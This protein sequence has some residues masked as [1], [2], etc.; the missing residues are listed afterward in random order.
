MKVIAF[1]LPQFHDI[2]EN[3]KWW[4]KGFT[5]WTNVKKARPLFDGHRQPRTP[6]NDN[7][8]CLLDDDV[9]VWQAKI[10]KEHGIYG[11]CYYH[12]WFLG[13]KLLEKPMEQMLA[14]PKIDIPFCICW[15]NDAWTKAWVGETKTIMEQK[16][17][18]EDD[19][20][21]HFNY[22]LSFFKDHRYIKEDNKP[23]V[24]IYRPEIIECLN[25]M[26][27]CWDR[28]ARDVGFDGLVYAYQ[29]SGL[30]KVPVEKRNNKMFK[31]DIEFEPGY[32]K[33]AM[34]K[35]A[36]Y[37]FR[38]IKSILAKGI[39]YLAFQIRDIAKSNNVPIVENRP[40][41]RELYTNL[42]VGDI[43]PQIY[44][45]VIATIYSQLDKFKNK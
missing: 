19:W 34:N 39:D 29:T 3:D 31:Y 23:L 45:N 8:Y 37:F 41:A 30:N 35:K 14:N 13:K 24:V 43:I 9:K 2:P 40:V 21:E 7:Y 5:E 20:K 12:Y 28:L 36:H 27:K 16:Y 10:A 26:L 44:F 15:A 42:K 1:Y 38:K 22:L 6:L 11:F 4:G 33:E 25:D 17:G 32:A 18:G